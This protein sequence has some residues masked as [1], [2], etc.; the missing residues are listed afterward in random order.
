[1]LLSASVVASETTPVALQPVNYAAKTVF[2]L[3]VVIALI[4]LLAW[5]VQKT[6]LGS[7][8]PRQSHEALKIVA[9][10]SLG[11]KEKIALVQVGEKQIVVGITAQNINLLT[12]LETPIEITKV[13][14]TPFADLLKKAIRS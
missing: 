13:P 14:P 1:M 2:F 4:V 12:E 8:L 5:L 6:K 3:L 9:V 10:T 11:I 7:Q